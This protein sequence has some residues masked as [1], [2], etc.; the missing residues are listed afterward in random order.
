MITLSVDNFLQA[1]DELYRDIEKII[2]GIDNSANTAVENTSA[3]EAVDDGG[4]ALAFHIS[5]YTKRKIKNS[6]PLVQPSDKG[7]ITEWRYALAALV[8]EMLLYHF[9]WLGSE[10]WHRYLAEE[11]IFD[12]AYAGR[13]IFS[14]IASLPKRYRNKKQLDQL[15]TIYLLVLELG[16]KGEWRYSQKKLSNYRHHLGK[17]RQQP[18]A[19]TRAFP[20]AHDPDKTFTGKPAK[21]ATLSNWLRYLKYVILFYMLIMLAIWLPLVHDLYDVLDGV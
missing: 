3:K 11:A 12:T 6:F 18:E 14:R 4:Q 16:F 8:D 1:Y 5:Q 9:E 21:L 17:W 19:P 2:K 13:K 20:Q 15:A 7:L 10:H